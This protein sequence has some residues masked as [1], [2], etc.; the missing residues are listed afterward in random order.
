MRSPYGHVGLNSQAPIGAGISSAD[1]S[2][3]QRFTVKTIA[4]G[5]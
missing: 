4:T 2:E 5:I 1:I 3:M